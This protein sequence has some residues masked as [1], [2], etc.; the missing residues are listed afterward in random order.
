MPF[1]P[2]HLG[3]GA[4]FKAIGGRHFSFMVFGGAQ[5][6]ID[7]EPGLGLVYGW[8]VLHGWTH[9]VA[10]ALAIGAV[11]GAIGRPIS[12]YALRLARIAHP[13]F[14]W[15]ASFAGAF[16]GT[17]SHV[18]LDALM[19]AD[20]APL[21]P[22]ADGN[23]WLGLVSMEAVYRGCLVAAVVGGAIVAWRGRR[24]TSLPENDR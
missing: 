14:T 23:P 8:P 15:T 9:T 13:P 7:I 20:I 22:F 10:G 1:T 16:V 17:F 18:A 4:V 2:F 5:V 21:R 19:H 12:E 11:A 6:L 3:P 24:P